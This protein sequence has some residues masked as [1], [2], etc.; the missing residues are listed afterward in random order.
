MIE[1]SS[2]V[3][4]HSCTKDHPMPIEIADRLLEL[5]QIWTHEGFEEYLNYRKDIDSL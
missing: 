2:G 3:T 5:K 1:P 4:E